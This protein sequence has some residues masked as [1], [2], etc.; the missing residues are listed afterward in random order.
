MSGEEFGKVDNGIIL[1]HLRRRE[2]SN[3]QYEAINRKKGN[4]KKRCNPTQ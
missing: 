1:L 2:V 3:K 4:K